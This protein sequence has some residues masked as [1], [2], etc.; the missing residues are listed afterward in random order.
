MQVLKKELDCLKNKVSKAEAAAVAVSL[1][2]EEESKMHKELRAQYKAANEIRQAAYEKLQNLKKIL[3]EK[4][5]SNILR[6]KFG[7]FIL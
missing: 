6:S 1:R 4:V 2:Y 7:F 5:S 3:Y